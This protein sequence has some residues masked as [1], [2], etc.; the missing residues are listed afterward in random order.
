MTSGCQDLIH[1]Y[2]FLALLMGT[3]IFLL[4]EKKAAYDKCYVCIIKQLNAYLQMLAC[5]WLSAHLNL[6]F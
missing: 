5:N 2:E 3:V 4:K 1:S 6:H